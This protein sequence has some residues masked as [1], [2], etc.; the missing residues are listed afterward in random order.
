MTRALGAPSPQ[1]GNSFVSW[2]D[3][4]AQTHNISF[5]ATNTTY[6]ALFTGGLAEFLLAG[7]CLRHQR[8]RA[9]RRGAFGLAAMPLES[10]QMLAKA[11]GKRRY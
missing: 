2:S 10:L 5:P 7:C 11:A 1:G 9:I 4:G 6:T 3:G 8:R